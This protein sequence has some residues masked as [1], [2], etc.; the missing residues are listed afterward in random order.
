MLTDVV[1]VYFRVLLHHL[2]QRCKETTKTRV[3]TP[4]LREAKERGT[5]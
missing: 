1:V 5:C 4:N 3:I 2:K